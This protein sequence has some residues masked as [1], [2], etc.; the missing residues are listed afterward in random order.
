MTHLLYLSGT[1]VAKATDAVD[2]LDSVSAALKLHAEGRTILPPECYLG[3]TPPRGGTARSISMAAHLDLN[4]GGVAGAKII[5]AN[6]AN[7]AEEIPRA[8]GLVVLFDSQTARPF[9]LM[10]AAR[11]SALRTAAVS[12]VAMQT[13]GCSSA[14]R[15]ALLGAGN[16]ASRHLELMLAHLPELDEVAI[17]DQDPK[18]AEALISAIGRSGEGQVRLLAVDSA[19]EAVH[20]RGIILAATTTTTSYIP[21]HW[22]APGAVMINV[23]LDDACPDV[24]MEADL[25]VVDDW[26]L[27]RDDDHRL[28][29]RMYR[30]GLVYGEEEDAV[31]GDARRVDTT[32]GKLVAGLHPGRQDDSQ[33]VLVNPFGMAIGDVAYAHA[34]YEHAVEAD[35][36]AHIPF[37]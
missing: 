15:A 5:N 27:V 31:D 23:S 18:R 21:F 33:I 8:S 32:L 4:G 14:S 26:D 2:P 16:I 24:V 7:T 6:P 17:F 10:N 3:W 37:D 25:L 22:L 30:Q 36:G 20:D 13:L 35:L 1:D 11:I 12:V 34:L 9:C 28:L 19:E 29:G